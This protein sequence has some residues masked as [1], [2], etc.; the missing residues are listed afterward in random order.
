MLYL[1]LSVIHKVY[2][3]TKNNFFVVA[4]Y[5]GF[6]L[7]D[8]GKKSLVVTAYSLSLPSET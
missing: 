7:T 5:L 8:I 4:F 6:S 2:L 3:F 1:K